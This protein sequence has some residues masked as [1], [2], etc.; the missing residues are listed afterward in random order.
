MIK[1]WKERYAPVP[2]PKTLTPDAPDARE[3]LRAKVCAAIN[4]EILK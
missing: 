1:T 3:A 4:K 2:A